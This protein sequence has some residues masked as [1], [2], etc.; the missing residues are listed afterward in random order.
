MRK[1]L[2]LAALAATAATMAAQDKCEATL[3]QDWKVTQSLP[4]A[5]TA[6]QG[7][8]YN[9]KF[10]INKKSTQTIEIFDQNGKT[11]S[12]LVGGNNMAISY[13]DA[14]NI[15][16]SDA[17][18]TSPWSTTQPNLKIISA[19]GTTVKQL[20]IATAAGEA[21]VKGR[22]DFMGKASG[23]LLSPE[24]G[25]LYL[26]GASNKGVVRVPIAN[27]TLNPANVAEV[28][29]EGLKVLINNTTV[30]NAYTTSLGLQRA[31]FANRFK[32]PVTLEYDGTSFAAKEVPVTGKSICNGAFAFALG[33]YDL[34]AYPKLPNVTDGFSIAQIDS[35]NV[36]AT[37]DAECTR[38]PNS[39]QAN[40]INVQVINER[41]ARIY[42]Y[43]PGAYIA[44]YTLTLT[45]STPTGVEATRA[46]KTVAS[47]TYYNLAGQPSPRPYN[48]LNL[49][50]T[51]YTDGTRTTQKLLR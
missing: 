33:G 27:G 26:V 32:S 16:V 30:V 50:V 13:D 1:F 36:V 44:Q 39:L 43:V 22:C 8:G 10:F 17:T 19:D 9:G 18:Y 3:T 48:G 34:V 15:L 41:T 12:T 45:G 21:A 2:L 25:V 28:P 14:G 51:T 31:I 38:N 20:T 42:Q 47:V 7:F 6:A 11:D 49:K 37:H 24:G 4:T 5:S 46:A 35:S 23:N 40:W 29:I